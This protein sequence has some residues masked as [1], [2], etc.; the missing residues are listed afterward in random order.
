MNRLYRNPSLS[1]WD[2]NYFKWSFLSLGFP[3]NVGSWLALPIIFVQYYIFFVF[4]SMSSHRFYLFS[5]PA[6]KTSRVECCQKNIVKTNEE[7]TSIITINILEHD[8]DRNSLKWKKKERRWVHRKKERGGAGSESARKRKDFPCFHSV[9]TCSIVLSASLPLRLWS[10]SKHLRTSIN[11]TCVS[12]TPCTHIPLLAL[13]HAAEAREHK[14]CLTP[15]RVITVAF[16][17]G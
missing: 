10:A 13:G 4:L 2:V 1:T 17:D 11:A 5:L 15:Y 14:L 8:I 9:T 6:L 12:A 7:T 3:I 16:P